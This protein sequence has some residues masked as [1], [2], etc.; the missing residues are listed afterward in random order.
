M[1]DR[2]TLVALVGQGVD[3]SRI[4]RALRELELGTGRRFRTLAVV[5][6]HGSGSI[7]KR[8]ADDVVELPPGLRLH[9]ATEVAPLLAARGVTAVVPGLG[10]S[11]PILP[12]AKRAKAEGW[13][14]IGP[15][16]SCLRR[17]LEPLRLRETAQSLGIATVPWSGKVLHSLDEVREHAARLGFPVLLRAPTTVQ[18]GLGVARNA[19]ELEATFAAA[20]ERSSRAADSNAGGVLLERLLPGVR[21]LEVPVVSFPDGRRWILDV[22]DAS[23]RRRDGSVMVEAPAPGLD[24][25]IERK[26]RAAVAQ[27][28]EVLRH[29]HVGTMAVLHRPGTTE[30]TFLGYDFGRGGEHAAAEMLRGIDLAKL[31]VALG[32]GLPLPGGDPPAPRGHAMAAQLRVAAFE[33]DPV[34]M[35]FRPASGPGVRT[36]SVARDGDRLSPHVAVAEI[37]AHG[38]D[39]SEALARLRGALA[40][41]AYIVRG[42]ETSMS[43]LLQVT[44]SP[45]LEAGPVVVDWWIEHLREGD[46]RSRQYAAEALLVAAVD[47]HGSEHAEDQKEFVASAARGRPDTRP[48][49][50]RAVELELDGR[51]H[52]LVVTALDVDRYEVAT[53]AGPV[54][55]RFERGMGPER[56]MMGG[57]TRYAITTS[58]SGR[59]HEVLVDGEPH[60]I[61]HRAGVV[62]RTDAPA[63]VVGVHVAEGDEVRAGAPLAT[64]ETM[65]MELTVTS[66][67]GGRVRRVLVQRGHQV[68][69]SQPLVWLSSAGPPPSSE[70]SRVDFGPLVHRSTPPPPLEVL[71]AFFRGFEVTLDSAQEAAQLVDPSADLGPLV[72]AFVRLLELGPSSPETEDAPDGGLRLGYGEYLG[73]FVTSWDAR[74]LPQTFLSRLQRAAEAY[75]ATSLERTTD[76]VEALFRLHMAMARR[77]EIVVCLLGLLGRQLEANPPPELGYEYRTLL[78][79]LIALT[80][81]I[82]PEVCETARAV[83]YRLF[84]GPHLA[85]LRAEHREDMEAALQMLEAGSYREAVERLVSGPLTVTSQLV[86]PGVIQS[87][88]QRAAYLEVLLRRYYRSRRL[89]T[90]DFEVLDPEGPWLCT[91]VEEE[92]SADGRIIVGWL[93][94]GHTLGDQGA[95]LG[96]HLRRWSGPVGLELVMLRHEAPSPSEDR[97]RQLLSRLDLPPSVDRVVFILGP[98]PDEAES[99]AS[100]ACRTFVRGP[101]GFEPYRAG[102]LHPMVAERLG[103]DRLANFDLELIADDGDLHAFIGTGKGQ[104]EDRRIF[105]YAE[106]RDLTAVRDESGRLMGFPELEQVCAEA[107]A[108]LR[109]IRRG[110]S[111]RERTETNRLELYLRPPIGEDR[112]ALAKTV[113]DL[114]PATIGL[115]L[116]EIRVH[117][118]AP[119]GERSVL[120]LSNPSGLGVEVRTEQPTSEPIPLMS[121]YQQNVA[122]LRRRGL[123][124]PYDLARRLTPDETGA[125]PELPRGHLQE[126]DL[127]PDTGRL[128]AVDRPP[129]ENQSNIIVGR[130]TTF[131]DTIPE[132]MTRVALFGDPSR[133]MG[134]LAEPE[135]RRIIAALDLAEELDV[136]AEWYAVSGGAEISKQRGTETMDW[137]SAVLRR[138][139]DFTHQGR[140]LNVVVCGINVGAQSYWNAEATMLMHTKGILVMVPGSA[141]VLTGK[142]TLDFSGGIS[143]EDNLGIGGYD[144]IM[145]P[146]GQAQYFAEDLVAAGKLLLRHYAHTYRVPGERFPRRRPTIDPVERDVRASPHGPAEGSTFTTVGDVFSRERNP[147]RKRPFDIRSV[148]RAVADQDH[149]PLERWRDMRDAETVVTWDAHLGGRPV[150]LLGI[151]SHPIKRVGHVPGDGPQVWTAGTF[152]PQSSRKMARSINAASCNRPL[153]ILANLSGFDGSPESIR[154]RQ[155]EYGAEIGRAVVGFDGPIVVTVVSR[156]HGGAFVVFSNRLHDNMEIFALEGTYASMIGGAPAAAVV[157]AR[158]LSKRIGADPRV[159]EAEEAVKRAS[160]PDKAAAGVRLRHA[161]GSAH[162]EH[163]AQLAKEYDDIHS[164]ERA[165]RVGSVHHIIPPE[166]LRPE[167]VAAVER[168]IAR[169]RSGRSDAGP[170]SP[171]GLGRG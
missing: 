95:V 122:K 121:T 33:S 48:P 27:F 22:I 36:D 69:P 5:E 71:Q 114:A 140:E 119:D 10:S 29:E 149:P 57:G 146:N 120:R 93:G 142:Q 147:G 86:R 14:L 47:A 12:W 76:L 44:R 78:D 17:W 92:G 127:D 20:V 161:R 64:L 87:S 138:I 108:C 98:S 164:V 53:E 25:A 2:D 117:A 129:G 143:A 45:E 125:T 62:V 80:Q 116:E 37:I 41:S 34:L 31:R 111:Q 40:E 124:H 16:V 82:L 30:V 97:L 13:H 107:L 46:L 156:F 151:E 63:I 157:F 89:S 39:R 106:V 55:L 52:Q 3:T 4:A 153:V 43:A 163:L 1:K 32:L 166:R 6:A 167:L 11:E 162:A 160:G 70:R 56:V 18:T 139:I 7:V 128:V 91:R 26:I 104:P 148:M 77:S 68:S 67:H 135:C 144:R 170:A 24:P 158:E 131:T 99:N 141:M 152:V 150:A 88:G 28:A 9:Q 8:S 84:D 21:R 42:G 79:R 115:G 51:V 154:K 100:A 59:V 96:A 126:F 103:I 118:R 60:R 159:V 105:V 112:E 72:A 109:R 23:L 145:G 81:S 66:Q 133:A 171:S 110:I 101:G 136:P 169:H 50:P 168:G 58:R 65:K 38:T 75:G 19:A 85:R 49:T 132:G 15:G 155:L 137:I 74:S 94:D 54:Q 113:R 130:I 73:S 165:Q 35:H 83:Q 90:D 102:T 134:A 61:V 123:T